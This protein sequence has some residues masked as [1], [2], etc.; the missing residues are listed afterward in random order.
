MY[1]R[2]GDAADVCFVYWTSVARKTVRI[3]T[4]DDHNRG[5]ALFVGSKAAEIDLPEASFLIRDTKCLYIHARQQSLRAQ[6]PEWALFLELAQRLV[7]LT[8][9]I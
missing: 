1:R 7:L 2:L 4:I 6:M 3:V 5:V 9:P 8:G